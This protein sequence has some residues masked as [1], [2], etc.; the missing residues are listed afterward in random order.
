METERIYKAIALID[1]SCSSIVGGFHRVPAR[2]RRAHS[3]RVCAGNV[4][5]FFFLLLAL[6]LDLF[7][8]QAGNQAA[9]TRRSI[10]R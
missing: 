9:Y 6:P 3:T 10:H 2:Q 1:S 5:P 7:V 4:V 8:V